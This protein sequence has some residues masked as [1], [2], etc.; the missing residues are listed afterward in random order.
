MG[1]K[2][3]V[4]IQESRLKGN[5]WTNY[6]RTNSNNPEFAIRKAIQEYLLS[7]GKK[8]AIQVKRDF[9]NWD[10]TLRHIPEKFFNK[11]GIYSISETDVN[12]FKP[13]VEISVD[14]DEVL[15]YF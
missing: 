13:L 15:I 7:E 5:I 3:V 2:F 4:L 1:D 11:H 10:D 14:Q 8:R 9:F 6:F 12:K